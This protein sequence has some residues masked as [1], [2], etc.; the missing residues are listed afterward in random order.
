MAD[1]LKINVVDVTLPPDSHKNITVINQPNPVIGYTATP[2]QILEL[3][4]F[5]RYYITQ[6]DNQKPVD[7][8]TFYDLFPDYRPDPGPGPGP[9]P[10]GTTSPWGY[11]FPTPTHFFGIVVESAE[12]D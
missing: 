8:T 1:T 12:H 2:D 4:H 6:T 10:S 5:P 7:G 3:L 11:A 9:S